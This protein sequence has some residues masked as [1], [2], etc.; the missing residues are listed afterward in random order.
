MSLS[1]QVFGSSSSG[2]CTTF[3]NRHGAVL[4]DCG[5]PPRYI[6]QRLHALGLTP[7]SVR[8]VLL[9]HVHGDHLHEGALHLLLQAGAALVCTEAVRNV[10]LARS[11]GAMLAEERGLLRTLRPGM[12]LADGISVRS[13]E[14]PHDTPGGCSGFTLVDDSGGRGARRVTFAT[15]LGREKY[16]QGAGLVDVLRAIQ[17]V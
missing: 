17:S 4:V 1:L 7:S 9:T 6:L 16:F 8:A 5:F 12:Q 13:F 11:P 2:N 14:V 10:L 15:D 3:W